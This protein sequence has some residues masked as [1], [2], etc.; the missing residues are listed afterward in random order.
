MLLFGNGHVGRALVQVLGALPVRVTWIDEREDDF[1]GERAG[2]RRRSSPPTRR[3]TRLRARRAG[4]MFLVMTHSHALDF[5]LVARDL[6]RDDCRYLGLIGSACEA[7][8][9]RA[10]ARRAR[11][12]AGRRSR[13]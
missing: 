6:A 10:A 5:E 3:R 7:R 9:V 4:S 8:A 1:P 2:Q 12:V 11:L 13:A